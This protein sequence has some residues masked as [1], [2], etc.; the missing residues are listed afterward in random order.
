MNNHRGV[1]KVEDISLDNC[2]KHRRVEISHLRERMSLKEKVNG[3]HRNRIAQ[4]FRS[5]GD[6]TP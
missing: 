4:A 6:R 3:T 2:Y 5:A 1:V